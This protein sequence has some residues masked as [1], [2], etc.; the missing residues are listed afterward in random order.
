MTG[1]AVVLHQ[2]R[3]DQKV[4]WRNPAAVFFTAEL[5]VAFPVLLA[6]LFKDNEISGLNVKGATYY[7]P[8]IISLAVISATTVK[9]AT[10]LPAEREA[11][12]LKRVRGTPLPPGAF[13]A[14]RVGNSLV[15][16]VIMVALVSVIGALLYGVS[17]P[18]H[19]MPAML[20][21]LAVGAFSFSRLGFGR[22][23]VIPTADAAPA[24][25]NATVL[26]LYFLSGVFIPQNEIP[27]GVLSFADVF[28]IRHF[29][30]AMFTAW[31][32]NTTGAG[33]EW[34]HLA[35]VAAWGLLGLAIA[36]RF[37]RWEPR[38]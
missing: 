26:P 34:G 2:F 10:N 13:V 15:I 17:I 12:Q 27:N 6:T 14:G 36:V 37:F 21:T 16:S 7:V 11:G 31:D 20:V 28:P 5:P 18:T 30:E 38:R 3:F 32:P 29:F 9:L 19:T 33:F 23:A 8:A 24:V 4:F 1:V 22:A 35:V 25:T